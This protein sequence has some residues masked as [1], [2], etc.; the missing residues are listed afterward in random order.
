[1]DVDALVFDFDGV[2]VDSVEVKTEAFAE[3]FRPHGA[4][5]VRAVVEHHRANGGVTRD[6]KFRHAYE[7]L[8]GKP[9]APDELRALRARFASLVVD[10]VVAAPEIPGAGEFLRA[11]SARVPCHVVSATPED[12]IRVIVD[13]RGLAPRF[14]SVRGAPTGKSEHL[15]DIVR[16]GGLDPAR[17]VFFGDATTDLEAARANGVRFQGIGARE[18]P[19]GRV[20]GIPLAPDFRH[21]HL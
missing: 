18:G 8:L 7:V 12:E 20:A 10:R 4:E 2:L 9:L 16:E 14:A 11:W 21:V 6:E 1:M 17:V 19:L 3:L 13:R 15:R 5:I